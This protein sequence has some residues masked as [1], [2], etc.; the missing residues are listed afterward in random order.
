M[1]ELNNKEAREKIKS[2]ELVKVDPINWFSYYIDKKTGEKWKEDRPNSGYHG[3]GSPR[4]N[5]ITRFPW[6]NELA[7]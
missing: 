1:E 3:G 2:L 4:L 7:N 6:E 5:K